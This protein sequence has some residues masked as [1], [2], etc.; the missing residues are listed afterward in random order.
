MCKQRLSSILV[1]SINSQPFEKASFGTIRSQNHWPRIKMGLVGLLVVLILPCLP[2]VTWPSAPRS[3]MMMPSSLYLLRVTRS[4]HKGIILH[5]SVGCIRAQIEEPL[6]VQ[7]RTVAFARDTLTQQLPQLTHDETKVPDLM[8]LPGLNSLP[9]CL[10]CSK[11]PLATLKCSLNSPKAMQR[12]G[13]LP[14]T[15]RASQ[16][17][18]DPS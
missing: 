8:C 1:E 16:Q 12:H 6:P 17:L 4:S 10:A 2:Y 13:A 3:S 9:R 15:P 11:R 14:S 7:H 5:K 18:S